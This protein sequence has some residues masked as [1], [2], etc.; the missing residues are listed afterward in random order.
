MP[1]T[2]TSTLNVLL[3]TLNFGT[4]DT[5]ARVPER[6]DVEAMLDVFQQ[7]GHADVRARLPS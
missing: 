4:K 1:T 2:Q 3:G 7:H 5:G 6:N